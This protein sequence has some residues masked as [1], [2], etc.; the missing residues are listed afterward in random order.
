MMCFHIRT[1][2]QYVIQVPKGEGKG[3]T[4]PRLLTF[5]NRLVP[6]LSQKGTFLNSHLPKEET[7]ALLGLD[8]FDRT[9][10]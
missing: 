7:K 2:H 5:G 6:E 9:M 3:P 10:W 1:I 4:G 8:S